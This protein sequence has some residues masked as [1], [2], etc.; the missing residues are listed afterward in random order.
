MRG[1]LHGRPVA[2]KLGDAFGCLLHLWREQHPGLQAGWEEGTDGHLLGMIWKALNGWGVCRYFY[3]C[4]MIVVLPLQ[5]RT[6]S[7]ATPLHLPA[8]LPAFPG[9]GGC[10]AKAEEPCRDPC[11]SLQS[12]SPLHWP[13]YSWENH[14]GKQ[15]AGSWHCCIVSEMA[16]VCVHPLK[17]IYI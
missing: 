2:G 8:A 16:T 7:P 5:G 9:K 11:S 3:V 10:G 6:I 17:H 12:V 14:L 15:R 13:Q 4:D 1:C